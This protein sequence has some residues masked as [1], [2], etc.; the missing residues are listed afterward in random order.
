MRYTVGIAHFCCGRMTS[1]DSSD[2][3][4]KIPSLKRLFDLLFTIPGLLIL[5]PVFISLAVLVRI[6]LG[7]PI[8]F[9]QARPGFL[10]KPFTLYKFRS[11]TDTRDKAGKLLPDEERLTKFGRFLRSTSLDELPELVNVLKG[12][13]SLVGPRPLLMQYLPRYTPDQARRHHV[14]PGL[15]GWAQI[16]GRNALTWEQKFALDVWYVE[17]WSIGLDIKILLLTVRKVLAREGI[18]PPDQAI[19]AEYMGPTQFIS[20]KEKDNSSS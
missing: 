6:F 12:E 2:A 8:I 16:N 3:A 5:S 10:G 19:A 4:P 1:M 9:S 13:M 15:T 11:M 20:P 17:H 7:A 14:L 18:E